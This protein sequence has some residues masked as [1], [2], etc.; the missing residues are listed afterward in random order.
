MKKE[1]NFKNQ[2]QTIF[3]QIRKKM[4]SIKYATVL[5]IVLFISCSSNDSSSEELSVENGIKYANTTYKVNKGLEEQFK[6]KYYKY[7]SASQLNV[8]DGEFY[9]TQVLISGNLNWI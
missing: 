7:H 5:S 6:F 1:R 9:H 4:K 2:K 3:V 8:T